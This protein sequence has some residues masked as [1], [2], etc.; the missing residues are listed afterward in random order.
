MADALR[1]AGL[2][3]TTGPASEQLRPQQG[4][5]AVRAYS[6]PIDSIAVSNGRGP[7]LLQQGQLR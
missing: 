1:E 3:T 7:G 2:V 4:R 6:W 5:G